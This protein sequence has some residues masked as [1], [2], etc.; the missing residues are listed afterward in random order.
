MSCHRQNMGGINDI[1]VTRDQTLVV[2][3]GQE[4]RVTFWDLRQPQVPTPA[5]LWRPWASPM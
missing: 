1:G 4:K 3:V 2:S 5:V